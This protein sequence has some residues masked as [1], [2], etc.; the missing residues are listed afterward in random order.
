MA[1]PLTKVEVEAY[2][3][4]VD[5]RGPLEEALNTA[6]SNLTRSPVDFMSGHFAAKKLA[7]DL[8]IIPAMVGPCDGLL[9]QPIEGSRY[10]LLL[11]EYRIP[12][13]PSGVGGADKGKNGHRVD[14]IPIANGVIKTNNCCFPVF[15]VPEDENAKAAFTRV[16]ARRSSNRPPH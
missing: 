15:Y 14:S 5:L 7:N 4:T 2:L 16:I 3:S 13:H 1:A 12:N 9:P 11:V 6:V 8:G 10:T